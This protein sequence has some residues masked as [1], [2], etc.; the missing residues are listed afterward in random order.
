MLNNF[1]YLP[2]RSLET[3]SIL[4]RNIE[5]IIKGWETFPPYNVSPQSI[6]RTCIVRGFNVYRVFSPY[7]FP[8]TLSKWQINRSNVSC[9]ERNVLLCANLTP[10]NCK[11][12]PNFQ[13]LPQ[14]LRKLDFR[15]LLVCSL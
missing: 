8:A 2:S 10:G 15:L 4:V 11:G 6:H 5:L 12:K 3:L 9:A 7:L 1:V 13:H 14:G